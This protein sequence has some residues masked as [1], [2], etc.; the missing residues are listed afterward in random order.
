MTHKRYL[1]DGRE[2]EYY[3][4][5]LCLIRLCDDEVVTLRAQ[6]QDVALQEDQENETEADLH[7]PL[8]KHMEAQ[9]STWSRG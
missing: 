7:L 5:C 4:Y 9:V 6:E 3:C 1:E 2:D 8:R